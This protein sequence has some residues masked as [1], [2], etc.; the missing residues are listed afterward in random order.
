MSFQWEHDTLWLW[1][2]R[3]RLPLNSHWEKV[4]HITWLIL[5]C[6][7]LSAPAQ[8]KPFG[9]Y[10]AIGG[11]GQASSGTEASPELSSLCLMVP[12]APELEEGSAL[13]PMVF[14]KESV[15]WPLGCT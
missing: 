5:G 14:C 13:T 11:K 8:H 1:H 15:Q 12:K 4:E 6:Q 7:G 9:A 2:P 10:G 3:R